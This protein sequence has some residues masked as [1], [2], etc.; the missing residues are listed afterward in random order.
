MIKKF[1]PNLSILFLMIFLLTDAFLVYAQNKQTAETDTTKSPAESSQLKLPDVIIYGKDKFVREAGKK[2][3]FDRDTP[4][5]I[6]PSSLFQP[7]Q[8]PD[9]SAKK[10]YFQP[11]EESISSQTKIQLNY[12]RFQQFGISAA[13]WKEVSRLDAGLH[14]FYRRSKGQYENSQFY[15]G[16]MRAQLGGELSEKFSVFTTVSFDVKNYGLYGAKIADLSRNVQSLELNLE[17][18]WNISQN[19]F[20]DWALVFDNRG[21]EDKHAASN[22]EKLGE[23]IFGIRAAHS[24]R[25]K[26]IQFLTNILYQNYEFNIKTTDSSLTQNYLLINSTIGKTFGK[27]VTARA[28]VIFELLNYS[29]SFS[30]T[31]FSPNVEIILAPSQQLG[32]K[33]SLQQNYLPTYFNDWWKIN[34]FI[35]P[36]ININPAKNLYK[37][38]A[39]GEFL[40]INSLSF[41]SNLKLQRLKN[42]LYWQKDS[43]S[44]LFDLSRL[45]YLT[46]ISWHSSAEISLS[47]QLKFSSGLNFNFYKIDD[48]KLTAA[49]SNLPYAEKYRIP[50]K[51]RFEI[52]NSFLAEVGFEWM[53]PRW[54]SLEGKEKLAGYSVLTFFVQ[55]QFQRHFAL[56]FSGNNLSDEKYDHWQNYPATG[57]FIE[58]GLKGSW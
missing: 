39:A 34:P 37:I 6:A 27:I 18:K 51:L 58:G 8:K 16:Q 11:G 12:G 29:D 1:K 48:K 3:I 32:F 42:Y 24:V 5:I 22:E 38:D 23:F 17:S 54:V 43:T 30:E 52:A 50:C 26:T 44:G 2:I 56:F 19:Q 31:Q 46:L 41:K 55:K 10:G 21:F 36:E 7:L 47:S 15:A 57:V 53:G 9:F 49:N 28:G 14:G 35:A 33:F 45:S 20:L 25:F 40:P 13:W 4:K